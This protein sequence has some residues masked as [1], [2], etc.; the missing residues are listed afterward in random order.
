MVCGE[1]QR[2]LVAASA[3]RTGEIVEPRLSANSHEAADGRDRI[4]AECLVSHLS[5]SKDADMA[6][7]GRA[8]GAMG[9]P[10]LE[11]ASDRLL[12]EGGGTDNDK[13]SI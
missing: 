2:F 3:V 11:R 13:I 8:N 9:R 4:E 5:G 7:S 6:P 12:P 10:D 1:C